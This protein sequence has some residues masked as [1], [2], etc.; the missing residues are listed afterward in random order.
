MPCCIHTFPFILWALLTTGAIPPDS[1]VKGFTGN[2]DG[3]NVCLAGFHSNVK[4]A[5]PREP[6]SADSCIAVQDK[7]DD[8]T[9]GVK[10]TAL[11]F[12]NRTKPI[13]GSFAASQLALLSI[14]GV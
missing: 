14:T 1:L 2:F 10:S 4:C 12:A 5:A 13:L 6:K 7:R 3:A 8:L 11:L 9:A